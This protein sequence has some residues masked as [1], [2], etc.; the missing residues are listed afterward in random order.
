MTKK[1]RRAENGNRPTPPLQRN[2]WP[3]WCLIAV[4]YAGWLALTWFYHSLPS[5]LLAPCA[6]WFMAWHMSLQ[7]ELLHGHPTRWR[8]VNTALGFAPL[9]LWLPYLRYREQH[10]LH[11]RKPYLTDP[12][13]DPESFYLTLQ[14]WQQR[15]PTA[16][17]WTRML[18]TLA[19]RLV[20]G[21]VRGI[22]SF[23]ARET[24][25]LH[26]EDGDL[27]HVWLVHM[28]GATAVLYWV[29]A[30]CG[31]P[32]WAY[33]LF[34][35]YP[36]YALSSLRAF[37]EHRAAET[38]D[39]R[40]AI[41]EC[42]P[43]L[44]LLFLHNNLHVLHHEQPDLPWY[45]I[46]ACYQANRRTLTRMN[47]GLVYRGYGDVV[48][49]YLFAEHHLPPWSAPPS[50]LTG[51]LPPSHRA[52]RRSSSRTA[53]IGLHLSTVPSKRRQ[54]PG[55][56]LVPLRSMQNGFRSFVWPRSRP[57]LLVTRH[58]RIE[59]GKVMAVMLGQTVA[60]ESFAIS[61][62]AGATPPPLSDAVS[63]R[64]AWRLLTA[65]AAKLIDVRTAEER[66]FVGYVPDSIHVAWA[67]GMRLTHNPLFLREL[68]ARTGKNATVLLLCRCGARSTAAAA[69]ARAAGF[70]DVHSVEEGFEGELDEQRHRGRNGWR[71]V[72][73]PW[74]QD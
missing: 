38:A 24:R 30:I 64:E 37:A 57:S 2:E 53:E 43:I 56:A 39:H 29:L 41:V 67:T 25:A 63:P 36:G 33:L 16:R 34:F 20:F 12:L 58:R 23:L 28:L 27:R 68:E 3:T 42:A 31:V 26:K 66:A 21:P 49:R 32:L 50:A 47:G 5:L 1:R 9:S 73:L 7:H 4:I 62:Y 10:I 54:R 19:G 14:A 52:I 46:P 69:A 40:T 61:T 59:R 17:A 70:S 6:A 45:A 55:T 60:P 15:G 72:G 65:G 35:V 13:E 71:A 11:H 51:R 18:N 22:A 8:G 44:G 74:V 48:R